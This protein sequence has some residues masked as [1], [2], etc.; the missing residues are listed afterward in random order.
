M[1]SALAPSIL[2]PHDLEL[3]KAVLGAVM[4][5]EGCIIEVV[6]ILRQ[7]AFYGPSHALIWSACVK[8]YGRRDPID[9]VTVAST[10]RSAGDLEAAGG[11]YYLSTLTAKVSSTAN[12]QY[13][14]LLLM[15]LYMRREQIRLGDRMARSGYDELANPHDAIAEAAH[16]LRM[17]SELAL[18]DAR[19]MSE[20]M[21][22][23]IDG[24]A[25]DR[26]V[27]FGFEALDRRI[28]VEP[29]T[30]TIIGARPAMGKTAFM[31]SSA[32]RQAQM[33]MRPYVVELEMRDRNLA[34][35]LACGE[36][37]VPIW[38]LKRNQCSDRELEALAAWHVANGAHTARMMIDE[39][40]TMTVGS[41]A[42]RLDRA[43]RR[44]GIDM[45]WVDYIGLLQPSVKVK[46]PYERMTA[47]SNELRV[48][49]KEIDLPFAVLA[50]LSRP[51]KGAA[52]RPPSLSDLRDSGEIEQDAEAVCFLH[53]PRY[54]DATAGDEVQFI[55]AKYRD[56]ADGMEELAFD[57]SGIRITDGL[58]PRTAPVAAFALPDEAHGDNPF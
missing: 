14:A 53:R 32:W 28:R 55:I 20:V 13:H 8:L 46:G 22:D 50:Q 34:R 24:K 7:G 54:Y 56:G 15:Q 30:V 38:K 16:E 42:A 40:A 43:K 41:L 21:G 1:A 57:P 33:G 58:P 51:M 31:L 47:I 5:N 10:L 9:L 37:G 11:P 2:P 52:V 27:P 45:V 35:R 19:P 6:E 18:N 4:L 48:L 39:A 23:V 49:S 25:K 12:V 44:H 36:T 17:L 3:E 29:G 26:G